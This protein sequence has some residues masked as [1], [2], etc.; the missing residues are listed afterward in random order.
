MAGQHT[1]NLL[2]RFKG[3]LVTITCLS[4]TVYQGRII[5]IT[6]DYVALEEKGAN[7]QVFVL[8]DAIESVSPENTSAG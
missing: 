1:E 7:S 3:E 5:E 4:T 6:N 8:F 2:R